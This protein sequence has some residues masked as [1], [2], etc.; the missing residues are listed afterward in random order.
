METNTKNAVIFGVVGVGL[1]IFGSY[2]LRPTITVTPQVTVE[3][4]VALDRFGAVPSL[5]DVSSPFI[6]LSGQREY[7]NSIPFAATS[8][9]PVRLQNPFRATT[10]VVALHSEITSSTVGA[11]TFDISTTSN[12]TGYGSSTPAFIYAHSISASAQDTA[13]WSP[14]GLSSTTPTINSALVLLN[15][16]TDGTSNF[17]LGPTDWITL[18][19]ATATAGTFAGGYTV[20]TLKIILRR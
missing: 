8:S 13:V 4:E 6:G 20:G 18:R 9:I 15:T 16:A 7:H 14:N 1:L 10:T 5:E 11:K 17:I 2:L 3:K 19:F 12:S